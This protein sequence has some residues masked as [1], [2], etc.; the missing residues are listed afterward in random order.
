MPEIDA[1]SRD[2]VTIGLIDAM[3]AIAIALNL[4]L[5]S[6]TRRLKR[7]DDEWAWHSKAV[8]DALSDLAHNVAVR[9]LLFP[10]DDEAMDIIQRAAAVLVKKLPEKECAL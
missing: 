4:R 7:S 5:K 10:R 6:E 3:I 9:N 8:Q 1:A 2:G